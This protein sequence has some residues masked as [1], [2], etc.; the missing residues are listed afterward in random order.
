MRTYEILILLVVFDFTL[1]SPLA[2]GQE[3]YTIEPTST[4]AYNDLAKKLMEALEPEGS[5]V[6]GLVNGQKETMCEV[7]WSKTIPIRESEGGRKSVLYG[8]LGVGT[9]V[10]LLHL[11]TQGEDSQDQK[12]AAGFYTMRYAQVTP[13][14]ESTAGSGYPDAV[15]LSPASADTRLE[16]VRSFDELVKMSRLASGADRPALLRLLPV[17][18]PQRGFPSIVV[19]DQGFCVL[20]FQLHTTS[21]GGVGEVKLGL[22][23]ITP[24]KQNGES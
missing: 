5:R 21:R 10:G 3:A 8:N 11:P 24:P 4:R 2:R 13:E 23:V 20:Q 1:A 17:N 15:L 9:F 14:G 12:L 7:W 22:L 18:S 6:L 19:D 16:Q